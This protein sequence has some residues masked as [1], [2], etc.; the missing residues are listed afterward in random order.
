MDI[1]MPK[2]DGV[3]ATKV[4]KDKWPQIKVI[5]LTSPLQRCGLCRISISEWSQRVIYLNLYIL[6]AGNRSGLVTHSGGT[7]ITK[8]MAASL[9]NSQV[10]RKRKRR[11][12][13]TKMDYKI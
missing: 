3:A 6:E 11:L 13:I 8:E 1:N 9:I 7:L 4:I 12:S 5:I 2:M 10:I